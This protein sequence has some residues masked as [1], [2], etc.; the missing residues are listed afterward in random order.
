MDAK[1]KHD[2]IK[3]QLTEHAHRYYVLDDP[4]ISDGEY[5]LLFE[6]LLFLEK[7]HPELQTPDSPSGRVGGPP[8]ER[9]QQV[10]HR[11][12]MLSLENAFNKDDLFAFEERLFRFLNTTSAFAYVAEPKIDG[13]AVEIIYENGILTQASTRGD[14]ETGE[15]I[16]SQLRTVPSIPLKL[17]NTAIPLL[18]VRGEVFMDKAGFDKLN[19]KQL[20]EGKQPFANPRN[21]AAGSLRQLDPAITAKRPLRFFSYGVSDPSTT[22]CL[23]QAELLGLLKDL[24]FP[25]NEHVKF[26]LTITDVIHC[27]AELLELRHSLAYDIDGMVV[28]VDPFHLQERLGNKARAPRWAIACKFPATQAT[29]QLINVEYQ[30]GRTGAVTPVAI[31]EPVNVDGAVVS[32]ATLHNQNELL[33]KDLRLGDT[34]LVQRAGDVIP[35]VVKPITDMRTGQEHVIRIPVNCPVCEHLLVKPEGEAVTRCPNPQCPAQKLRSLCHFTSKAGLDIEGLGKRNV[36]QLFEL[37]IIDEI[38]DIFTLTTEKLSHLDGWGEKSA[39]NVIDAIAAR[40]TPPLGKLLSAFGIRFLGEVT[41]SLL[42]KH[43]QSLEELSLASFDDLVE[44]EG[45][46]EQTAGSILEYFKSPQTKNMVLRL[47]ATGLKITSNAVRPENYFLTDHIFLFTGTLKSFSRNE[48]KKLIKENGGQVATSL[49]K[50]VTHL[51]AGEKAG[52][53]LKKAKELEKKI[54]TEK[55]FLQLIEGISKKEGNYSAALHLRPCRSSR[56]TPVRFDVLLEPI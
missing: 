39:K 1:I 44:I 53:K 32:R 33:R 40:S 15:D 43:F 30:V 38:P 11:V 54:L 20:Q 29:T 2:Q 10:Q 31:L 50:K 4:G 24:G 55:D 47:H 28:K 26:C 8:L 7:K 36:E 9:F 45:I 16:T 6:E 35:E 52:S 14:G 34:V 13:L 56:V 19:Q 27:F 18:E 49:T 17:Q 51:V 12:P 22:A 25:T 37:G 3:K 46:G 41:A 5:D 42:E 23:G 21:A 48:A